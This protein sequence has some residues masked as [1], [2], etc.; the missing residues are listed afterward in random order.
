MVSDVELDEFS[1]PGDLVLEEEEPDKP[2]F[3]LFAKRYFVVHEGNLLVAND[4]DYLKKL[5][6]QKQSK[7]AESHDYIQIKE[8]IEKLTNEEDICWRQFGRIDRTLEANYEMLR[9]GEMG[10][11]ANRIGTRNQS[12]VCQASVRTRPR[13]KVKSWRKIW[14]ESRNWMARS[15]QPTTKRALHPTL[16]RRAGSWKPT[17]KA[18]ESP[19][20]SQ[21]KRR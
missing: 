16:A 21:K 4:K 5:L 11:I 19:D 18:G 6:G 10:T 7:L 8:A 17:N 1:L 14:S 2:T 13:P 20:A 3:Q 12:D 15:C 9:R